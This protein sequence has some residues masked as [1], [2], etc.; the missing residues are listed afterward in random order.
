MKLFVRMHEDVMPNYENVKIIPGYYSITG[1]SID[2]ICETAQAT[3]ILAPNVLDYI[4]GSELLG[5]LQHMAS[6]L[7][8][9][10]RMIVGG[11]DLREI[12]RQ[13]FVEEMS[14][15]DAN[16]ILY[17][18]EFS[19]SRHGVFSLFE[20]CKLLQETG[21]VLDK[22]RINGTYFVVEAYRA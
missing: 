14:L 5:A 22:K 16:V 20:V 1:E 3:E 7:R 19:Q 8:H 4:H 15:A 9:G 18:K 10:R 13:L 11:N 21:L 17:G 12:S 6:K 2:A